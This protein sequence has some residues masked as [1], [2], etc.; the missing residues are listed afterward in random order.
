MS[1]DQA[2]IV[3]VSVG[4]LMLAAEVF[5]P[6]MVL[7]ILGGLALAAAVV[8]AYI[9]H[10]PFWGTVTFIGVGA[11]TGLGF[12]A[13]LRLFPYTPVGKNMMLKQSLAPDNSLARPVL[14]GKSGTA[15]TALRPAGTARID[16]RRIDVVAVGAFVEAGENVSV[17][18]EEGLS[19]VVR[20]APTPSTGEK[21]D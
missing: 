9:A 16:G 14:L 6:G 18:S 4:F 19:V 13:W 2:V 15:L 20:R 21:P 7:G 5:V 8:V 10:G 17:V 1:L 11:A 12:I 3:L